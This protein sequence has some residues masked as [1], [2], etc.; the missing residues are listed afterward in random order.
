MWCIGD[1][2]HCLPP[3]TSQIR[4]YDVGPGSEVQLWLKEN[5]PAPGSSTA[6]LEWPSQIHAEPARG[7]GVGIG[8]PGLGV[9]FPCQYLTR[10]RGG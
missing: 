4:N 6:P 8:W 3:P 7:E 1:G 9:Q 2:W 10:H 5:K